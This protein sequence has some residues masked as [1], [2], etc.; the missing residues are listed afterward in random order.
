M[1]AELRH[2]KSPEYF[3]AERAAEKRASSIGLTVLLMGGFITVFDLFVVNIAIP[4]IQSDLDANFAEIGFV[5]AGYALA[6]GV[7]LIAGGRLGDIYGRRK[8][9]VLGMLGFSA[10]S[11]LCGVAPNAL[12]LIVAR[13]LQGMT[14]A[15]L[16][17]Q[18]YAL[19]RV[20]FDER[21]RRRAF[22]LLGM[23]LG[24]AAIAGQ[25][26]GGFLVEG[27]L[28]GLGWRIVFVV[29][30]PIGIGAAIFSRS[31]PES[32]A[33]DAV[34]VDWPGV[35]LAT[36]GLLLLL[37]PLLEGPNS[38]WPHWTWLSLAGAVLIVTLFLAWERRLSRRGGFPVIDLSLFRDTGFAM[39][40]IVVLAIYS[41]A[42]SFFL[43]FAVLLQSGLGLSPF[44]AGSIFAPASVGFIASS[45]LAPRLVA[46]RGSVAIAGGALLYAAG[47][48]LLIVQVTLSQGSMNPVR[49]IPALV[50]FGFG[51]GLSMTPLLNLVLG[52]VQE[53][54]AG[55]AA[56]V[57]TTMQQVG[58]AFGVSIVGMLF[59]GILRT[60]VVSMKSQ[61]SHYVRAFTGAMIYN[62][63][64]AFVAAL[65]IFWIARRQKNAT[66]HREP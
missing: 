60:D 53:R 10:T 27:N 4:S 18:I 42:T 61:S 22:G 49:L 11:L 14:G 31:I 58:S 56:G 13:F 7:L 30:V 17:P 12:A 40:T 25:V 66:A 38:G 8:L 23:T 9:F 29:N 32:K 3:S 24:L 47:I 5:V 19:L 43:C 51:Q 65:L 21:G 33:I 44:H 15:I 57:I 20:M 41:T 6:F 59:L 54:H 62:L 50:V 37:I 34:G 64:A 16:F 39:G 46:R 52:F 45:L 55:M 63:A 48:G 35:G 26:L 28:F 2:Q 1:S 36:L